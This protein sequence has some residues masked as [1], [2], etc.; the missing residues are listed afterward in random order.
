MCVSDRNQT[1]ALPDGECQGQ[2]RP[3]ETAPCA[4]IHSCK[5]YANSADYYNVSLAS[6]SH[7]KKSYSVRHTLE[8][9]RKAYPLTFKVYQLKRN[10]YMS[11]KS[12][13]LLHP[14]E[15]CSATCGPGY[16]HRVVICSQFAKSCDESTKPIDVKPC[17]VS[18]CS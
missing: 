7:V 12:K 2:A 11:T 9:K 16:Q 17:L 10:P 14:W 8:D 4:N 18:S 5:F 3:P 15:P 1:M 6:N 13:W